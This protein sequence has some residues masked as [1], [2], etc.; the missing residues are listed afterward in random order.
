MQSA[1][2]ARKP[3]LR[4]PS[5]HC[6]SCNSR[7]VLLCNQGRSTCCS[8]LRSSHRLSKMYAKRASGHRC[9]CSWWKRC[10]R[11]K[12]RSR[13]RTIAWMKVV[14][15][16]AFGT[17][18]SFLRSCSRPTS[19][20]SS[21]LKTCWKKN[22]TPKWSKSASEPWSRSKTLRWSGSISLQ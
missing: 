9:C 22:D 11:I 2:K 4:M 18:P 15:Q 10:C 20:Q 16:T 6:S 19:V 8:A 7:W 3:R 5:N 14:A 13:N 21:S 1:R 17:R 12:L